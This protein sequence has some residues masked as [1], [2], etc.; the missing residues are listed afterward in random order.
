VFRQYWIKVISPWYEN[1]LYKDARI[2]GTWK[3]TTDYNG[4][5]ET[6]LWKF[7][8][9]GH[10]IDGT[11]IVLDGDDVGKS[12]IVKGIFKNLIL[13]LTYFATDKSAV[14]RGT[15][16]LMLINNGHTLSG[17]GTYYY[18][19]EHTIKTVKCTLEKEEN[20]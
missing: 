14:D 16:N 7:K 10:H 9:I 3:S 15:L 17:Y 2:E 6:E 5:T 12:Y 8:Q 19:P 20:I 1:L 18:D 11:V 13:T 4:Y